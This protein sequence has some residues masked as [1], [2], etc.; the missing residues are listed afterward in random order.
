[1]VLITL[2]FWKV[3]SYRRKQ[4]LNQNRYRLGDPSCTF[5]RRSFGGG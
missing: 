2:S 3:L 5:E 4:L 1:M